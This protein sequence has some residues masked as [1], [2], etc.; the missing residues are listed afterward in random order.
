[1][2][3]TN[4][5]RSSAQKESD[6]MKNNSFTHDEINLMCIYDVGSRKGLIKELNRT[7]ALMSKEDAELASITESAITKLQNMTDDQYSV[8]ELYP[9]YL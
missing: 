1:M 5:Q 9:D 4:E 7:L 8:L 3:S 6:N 2:Q